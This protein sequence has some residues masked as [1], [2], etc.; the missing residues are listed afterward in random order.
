MYNN[1]INF[2]IDNKKVVTNLKVTYTRKNKYFTKDIFIIMSDQ[3]ER[4][5]KKNDN[6]QFFMD[7]TYYATPPNDNTKN[8]YILSL[9]Y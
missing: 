2:T 3:M 7:V 9:I 1:I 4:N 6:I 5:I 8:L